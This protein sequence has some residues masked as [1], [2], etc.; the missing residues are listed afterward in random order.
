M[1]AQQDPW[2]ARLR[3]L[4]GAFRRS[5]ATGQG[6][7]QRFQH[8]ADPVGQRPAAARPR[9]AAPALAAHGALGRARAP[10]LAPAARCPRCAVHFL[11]FP[12]RSPAGCG[13]HGC[14][15][16][17]QVSP[18]S[19]AR[20]C[21]PEGTPAV[22]ARC[23]QPAHVGRLFSDCLDTEGRASARCA[24]AP[25]E[26]HRRLHRVPRRCA[27]C[28]GGRRPPANHGP[29]AAAGRGA[30]VLLLRGGRRA[31]GRGYA[32]ARRQRPVPGPGA[33]LALALG[34]AG[35]RRAALGA[36]TAG[37]D[38]GLPARPGGSGVRPDAG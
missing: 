7:L 31:A 27:G 19:I 38:S 17:G 22:C 3:G 6:E 20:S 18:C 9:G 13:R 4:C 35:G 12:G 14:N 5:R 8:V 37:D 11:L 23:Y 25:P 30:G 36:G 26:A 34:R 33:P 15:I 24:D 28:R 10:A 21:V 29:L 2:H 32:S 1:P 16:W